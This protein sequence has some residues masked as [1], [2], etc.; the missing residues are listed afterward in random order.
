MAPVKILIVGC[1]I[2]GPTLATFLLLSSLPTAEKPHITILE[3]ASSIRKQGQNVDIRGAG[4]T[5]IRKLGLESVIRASTTGEI[6]VQFVDAN[7]TIW[8]SNRADKT[9]QVSTPTADIEILRGT[10]AEICYRRCKSVSEEVQREGGHGVEF[11]FGD[12][13]DK[14]DQ[15]GDSVT[16]HFAKSDQSRKFDLVV[17]ADGLQSTVRSLT[18][19]PQRETNHIHR[20]NMYSAFFSIPKGPTDSDWRRWFHAPG[21]KS[22]M[23]RPS[24]QK[25]RTTVFMSVVN[26]KDERLLQVALKG[27]EDVEAQ[28]RLMVEYFEGVG[29]ESKRILEG[30]RETKDFYYDLVGQ[31]K[32]ESW[33]KGRVVLVGDAG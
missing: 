3:R 14:L 18:W 1:S 21:R 32:M 33:S 28:K 17:G 4:V 9:G 30:M 13:L 23:V 12:T 22:I 7:N 15:D 24:D 6:G 11:I 31:V 19:G 8:T 20:L 29:W 5:I 26:D 27:R 10:L 2:A 16:V 25:D